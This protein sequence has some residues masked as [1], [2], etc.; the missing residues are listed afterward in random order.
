MRY[1]VDPQVFERYPGF[2]RAV[3]IARNI[4]NKTDSPELDALLRTCEEEARG[5]D[6]ED[7]WN[8]PKLAVWA[9]AFR[10]MNLNPK[11]YPP[12]IINLVKRVRGG[13][14]L[15]YINSLVTA[16]NCVSLRHLCPCGGDDLAKLRGDLYLGPA[17]GDERYVP[18]G[19][20]DV[21]ETPPPGE[22]IYMDS[23]AKDVFC[24]AWCWKNGDSSKLTEE[25]DTAAINIDG[26]SPMQRG[27][28]LKAAEELCAML[29]KFTGATTEIHLLDS[30]NNEFAF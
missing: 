28:L 14:E 24:R 9:E 29:Q 19:Q 11:K 30:G 7:F 26:M 6:L 25:T 3:V 18:L 22:I 23:A 27:E 20:P 13:K 17:K 15:P 5:G 16:F 12:S 4:D 21:V 2:F 8:H 1:T 10:S